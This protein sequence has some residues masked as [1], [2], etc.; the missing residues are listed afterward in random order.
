M[1]LLRTQPGGFVPDDGIAHLAQTPAEL[2][3][4]CS[5]DSHLALLAEAARE[6]P[7]DYPSLRLAN[8]MQLQNHA[9]VD[10]YVDEVLQHARV[11]LI[12]VHGG[13]GYWR[14]GIEQLVA[15][16]ER[17]TQLIL[18]PG[19]DRPD[20]EL[21][22]LCT[23]PAEDA[24]RYWQYLRQGGLD[25]ARQLFA[26]LASRCLG[27]DYPW[28]APSAL[29][30]VAVHHPHQR[31]ARLEHWRADWRDGQPVVA[32]LFYRTHLQAAN[33]AFI[34]TFCER[35]AAVGI[36]PLPIAVASLKEAECLAV[37]EDWLDAVDAELIINTTGF[38]QSNPDT[39]GQRPFRRDVPVLQAICSLDNQ[40]LWEE[41]PQGLGPRDLAMHIALPELDGRIITRPISFKGLAWRSERSQSDVV[42]YLPHLER[43]DFVAELARR[44][45]LLARKANADKRVALILANYPTRD[46]RIGNGVGLDTRPPR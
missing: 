24:E 6:L 44:W 36:N 17:G 18:V 40:P 32:L 5:G 13:V 41:N 4:L 3:I 8:P 30:R 38:A 39:P 2:V 14:Y 21:A 25:N 27:R 43:M 22:R 45:L 35:L 12:S 9:S 7:Q 29:P 46:G 19:D 23:V 1:H 28:Q 15:L 42:C 37:V 33:T 31:P 10:L 16:A 34:D 20:P 26:C 11:I